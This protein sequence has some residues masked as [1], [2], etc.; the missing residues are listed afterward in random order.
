MRT[1]AG[2]GTCSKYCRRQGS[3][4]QIGMVRQ[5][6]FPAKPSVLTPAMLA[7]MEGSP[8]RGSVGIKKGLQ[9]LTAALVVDSARHQRLVREPFALRAG[10]YP[11][12][13]ACAR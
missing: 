5:P 7:S 1:S 12:Q 13:V 3:A 6:R 11:M 4:S 9:E 8:L 10:A 2:Q